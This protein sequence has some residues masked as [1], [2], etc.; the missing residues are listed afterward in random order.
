LIVEVQF[1][2]GL[3]VEDLEGAIRRIEKTIRQHEP[4]M[5]RISIQPALLNAVSADKDAA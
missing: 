3:N 4:T 1:R 5:L 2:R